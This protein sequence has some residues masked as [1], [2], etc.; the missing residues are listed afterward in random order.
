MACAAVQAM[1]TRGAPG[2]SCYRNNTR[3]AAAAGK[4]SAGDV[5][6]GPE[7]TP[8][9][10]LRDRI[11]GVGE[12][13]KGGDLVTFA[14][15]RPSAGTEVENGN[16]RVVSEE[17]RGLVR[18]VWVETGKRTKAGADLVKTCVPRCLVSS[19]ELSSARA[20]VKSATELTEL[21]RKRRRQ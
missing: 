9:A 17:N 20:H 19:L 14:R 5:A 7:R 21:A 2:R 6:V 11:T 16:G 18:G 3:A 12:Q 10:P 8:A 1:S 4:L 13:A 15:F